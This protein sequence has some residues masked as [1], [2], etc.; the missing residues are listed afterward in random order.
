MILLINGNSFI[1]HSYGY[2]AAVLAE[3]N[4]N[5]KKLETDLASHKEETALLKPRMSEIE[6]QKE[7]IAL[8]KTRV[9]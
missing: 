7:E 8:L 6:K 4:G 3:N 5:A 9:S 2:N 1:L